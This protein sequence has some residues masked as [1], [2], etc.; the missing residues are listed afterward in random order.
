MQSELSFNDEELQKIWE[1]VYA[2]GN[3]G[4][5]KLDEGEI[6]YLRMFACKIASDTIVCFQKNLREHPPNRGT[7]EDTT[8]EILARL[9]CSGTAL[10]RRYYDEENRIQLGRKQ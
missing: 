6:L 5:E 4:V 3:I 7:S 1:D 10:M 2:A 8:L 9:E